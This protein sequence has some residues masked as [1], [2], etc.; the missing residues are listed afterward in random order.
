MVFLQLAGS[1]ISIL[2]GLFI[3]TLARGGVHEATAAVFFCTGAVLFSGA[4]ITV[5]IN[6]TRQTM[7]AALEN[8]NKPMVK[9]NNN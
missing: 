5:A 7:T 8:A 2:F 3:M 4:S 1:A 9:I 6:R